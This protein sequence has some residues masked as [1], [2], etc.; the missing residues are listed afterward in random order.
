MSTQMKKAKDQ[1][2]FRQTNLRKGRNLSITPENS[3][4]KHLV[5]GRIILDKETPRVTFATGKLET[6]LICLSGECTIK[7]DGQTT[8]INQYDSIYLPRDTDVEITTDTSVDLVECS[9]EVEKKYPLQVVRYA[10]V[11]KDGSLKFKTGGAS[12]SRTVNITLGKNVEAGRIL[13][14]FTTSEP[15]QWTSWPP[16]EHAAI[17]EA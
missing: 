17:L 9:A 5:Y 1:L 7:A 12:N 13:A 6:G 15:G 8:V 11:E 10:D 3:A 14:G 4:M 16:H 2:I